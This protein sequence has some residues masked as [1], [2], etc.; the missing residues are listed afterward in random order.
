IFNTHPEVARTALVG[1]GPRPRQQPVVVVETRTHRW[2]ATLLAEL[3]ALA[4]SH[5]STREL[6][7][8]LHF[9]RPLPVDVRHN[10]K[11]QREWLGEWASRQLCAPSATK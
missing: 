11:I 2:S 1:V 8:F 5:Q 9:P 7:C 10:T 4:L 6:S 3:R